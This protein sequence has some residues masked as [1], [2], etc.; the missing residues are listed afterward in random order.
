MASAP[1]P[2][3]TPIPGW[4][5]L[6]NRI[7][8]ALALRELAVAAA[9]VAFAVGL[10]VLIARAGV[11]V[12]LSL[13]VVAIAAAVGVLA[14]ATA[15]TLSQ[16][17]TRDGVLALA[18]ARL[19]AGGTIMHTAESGEPLTLP[20]LAPLRVRAASRKTLTALAAG[21]AFVAVAALAPKPSLL[22][23]TPPLAIDRN[24]EDIEKNADALADAGAIDEEERE[25]YDAAI[26]E[27]AE[28]AD[29]RRPAETWE[30]L[31]RL[32]DEIA[33]DAKEG[34]AEAADTAAGAGVAEALAEHLAEDAGALPEGT[35]E[36]LASAVPE[37][38]AS[39]GDSP[40]SKEL[41]EQLAKAANANLSE[42]ERRAA[43]ELAKELAKK[44]GDGKCEGAGKLANARLARL[45]DA[46]RVAEGREAARAALLAYLGECKTGG[47]C[48][49]TAALLAMC[50]NP[51]ISR[52]PGATQL[53]FQDT[54][55]A[56]DTAGLTPERLDGDL[57]PAGSALAGIGRTA[58]HGQIGDGSTGGAIDETAAGP[59]YAS[60]TVVLP[61]HRRAVRAYFEREGRPGS[62]TPSE[63]E[64]TP[65]GATNDNP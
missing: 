63:P 22:A 40:L 6:R 19:A 62:S 37:L 47:Q 38:A 12:D 48:A 23:G 15:R 65:A 10:A 58:Q 41:L 11:G 49:S 21:V 46:A 18:D 34:I 44:L 42:E 52:G 4:P 55:T 56:I 51:N 39:L 32:A 64:P 57:D 35:L 54:T 59:T 14:L 53:A 61:R 20:D 45:S 30:A 50:S 33:R 9:V 1:R 43:A 26:Q 27:V 13:P 7:V 31:D 24:L 17:P 3:A 29:A 16:W 8:A 60:D 25:Q 5:A 28:R 36:A 2:M